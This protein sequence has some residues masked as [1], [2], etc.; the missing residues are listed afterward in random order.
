MKGTII[1]ASGQMC[2]QFWIYSN[3]IADA[4]DTNE[5]VGIWAPNFNIE[6]FPS[7]YH[8]KY[9]RFP[10]FI[11]GIIKYIGYKKYKKYVQ[12]FLSARIILMLC[13]LLSRVIPRISFKIIDIS[14]MKSKNRVKYLNQ[15]K[16]LFAPDKYILDDVTLLFN[17]K[18]LEY[19]QIV[20]IHIRH[21]DYRT[22]K[23]GKYFYQLN[24]YKKI[25]K[26]II[27]M[28]KSDPKIG[29]FI[30]CNENINYIKFNEFDFFYIENPN[31]LKDLMG[32]SLC[33]YIIGPPS[34]YSAWASL[35]T[36]TPLYFVEDVKSEISKD[37]FIH[38]EDIWFLK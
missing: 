13:C 8:S 11:K 31:S 14:Y 32:L 28:F 15:L 7:L 2:N 1:Y 4:I 25:M 3:F 26:Q 33:D 16:E 17:S 21:G 5:R 30:A 23:G 20:G 38:I 6:D 12:P 27:S 29:F 35:Y 34:S 22:F 36:H 19:N 18:R 37:K 9:V 24:E 10:F